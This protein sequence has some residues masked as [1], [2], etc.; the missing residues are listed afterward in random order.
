MPAGEG[1]GGRHSLPIG[2]LPHIAEVN[3]TNYHERKRL[4]EE[5][6]WG[7]LGNQVTIRQGNNSIVWTVVSDYCN[8]NCL[9]EENGP[10][11]LKII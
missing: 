1:A 6:I 8:P 9:M 11:G 7:L 3:L 10:G 4:A 2:Q 5:K